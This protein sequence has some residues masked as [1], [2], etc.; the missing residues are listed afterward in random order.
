MTWRNTYNPPTRTVNEFG[1]SKREQLFVDMF[2]RIASEGDVS[3]NTV[4]KAA[5]ASCGNLSMYGPDKAKLQKLRGNARARRMIAKKPIA[6]AIQTL[7]AERGFDLTDALDM[8]IKHVTGTAPEGANYAALK[9][10][11]AM[12]LPQ[13]AKQVRI[14]QQTAIAHVNV[15]DMNERIGPPPMAPRSIGPAQVE[16]R[17]S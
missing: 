11:L 6:E 12:Q 14:Q 5:I 8:H 3:W 9:D 1:L 13:P 10:L 15:S 2:K 7:Y 17:E 16:R 4:V